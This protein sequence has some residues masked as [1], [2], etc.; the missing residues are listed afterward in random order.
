M[1][2]DWPVQ[3][4]VSWFRQHSWSTMRTRVVSYAIVHSSHAL[5]KLSSLHTLKY[6]QRKQGTLL[7]KAMF[8]KGLSLAS[9][10]SVVSDRRCALFLKSGSICCMD[11]FLHWHDAVSLHLMLMASTQVGFLQWVPIFWQQCLPMASSPYMMHYGMRP[12]VIQGMW[13]GQHF[14]RVSAGKK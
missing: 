10:S 12:S 5:L 9:V 1:H 14:L 7:F 8:W 13:S 4:L 11:A 3:P 2:F 6:V